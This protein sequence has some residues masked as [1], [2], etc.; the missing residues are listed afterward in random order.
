M[1]TEVDEFLTRAEVVVV[2]E[3][4]QRSATC[5]P[6]PSTTSLPLLVTVT[7][8]AVSTFDGN[9]TRCFSSCRSATMRRVFPRTTP[10]ARTQRRRSPFWSQVHTTETLLASL[11]AAALT[12]SRS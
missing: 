2:S 9:G 6:L 3:K 8:C 10:V 12:V 1:V 7:D 11:Q 5:D 4:P